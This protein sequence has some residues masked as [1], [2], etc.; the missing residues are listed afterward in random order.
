MMAW[1]ADARRHFPGDL[2]MHLWFATKDSVDIT[3]QSQTV[4]SSVNDLLAD[5]AEL[6]PDP[7]KPPI[8]QSSRLAGMLPTIN[9]SI[10]FNRQY[11]TTIFQNRGSITADISQSACA[12]TPTYNST[13]RTSL[14]LSL[15]PTTPIQDNVYQQ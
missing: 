13:L 4:G 1:R 5:L 12:F 6:D 9:L 7:L 2:V 3:D 8:P 10:L 15:F 11:T 14:Q